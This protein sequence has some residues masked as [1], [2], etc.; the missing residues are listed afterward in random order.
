M[1]SMS[2]PIRI[3]AVDDH[4]MFR[5]GSVAFLSCQLPAFRNHEIR[6]WS[7]ICDKMCGTSR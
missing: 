6:S 1:S 5:N 3:L 2:K 4:L 7:S